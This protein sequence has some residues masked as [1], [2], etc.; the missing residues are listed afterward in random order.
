MVRL[1]PSV[2]AYDAPLM[3]RS[4][5]VL[6]GF[7]ALLA[8]V[9]AGTIGYVLLGF[10]V[11]DAIYQTVTT[12]TT[13]GFR[14][15][16]PLSGAGKIFTVVLILAGVGTAL[17]TLTMLIEVIVEG[18][19]G[20][21]MERRRMDRQIHEL[22]GHVVVCGWGRVGRAAARELHEAG[23]DVVVIDSDPERGATVPR[24]YLHIVG[25]ASDD[26]VLRRAGI[27]HAVA[28]VAAVET[29]AVNLFITL[30]GRALRKDLMIVARAREEASVSK[31]LRGGADRV[32]NPQEIGGA[33][34]A[35]FVARPRVAEFVDVV[36]HA[37]D[38]EL[39]LEEITIH[40][41]SPL[42]GVSLGEANIREQTGALVLALHDRVA[43]LV[44]V[45]GSG[46]RICPNQVLIA[47]GT[48]AQVEALARLAGDVRR[49]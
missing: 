45:P 27:D 1:P 23:R 6:V 37:G 17:Y 28:L 48:A 49:A 16:N 26:D 31:L 44:S 32:V 7:V 4:R 3:R 12:I 46:F 9:T 47:V 33:R 13:V 40:E 10:G 24:P 36:M 18:H 25:D 43:G 30:S 35:A 22:R 8:V 39:V 5:Q 34:I 21:E 38:A 20:E 29:D 41:T 42:A 15:V 19:L 2:A 14:E 11:L